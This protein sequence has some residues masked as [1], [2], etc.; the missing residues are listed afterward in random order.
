MDR[1]AYVSDFLQEDA[2]L[3]TVRQRI[4]DAGLPAISVA[5]ELGRLLTLLVKTARAETVLEIGALGGYSGICLARG[6]GPEGKLISLELKPEFAELARDNL[7]DAG[8]A[9]KVEYRVGPALDSLAQLAREGWRFDVVFIDADKPNY[10][11]YLDYALAL[12]RPGTL[13]LADNVLLGDRVLDE[14][15]PH[16]SPVAMR[17]FNQRMKANPRLEA[18]LLPVHDGFSIARVLP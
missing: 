9:D 7:A 16:P 5:P 18:T 4:A 17:T 6:L 11:Q 2:M 13:I 1:A 10:P 3:R 8:L 15:L 14:T 12:S